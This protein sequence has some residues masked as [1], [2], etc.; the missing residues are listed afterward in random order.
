MQ[1]IDNN[2]QGLFIIFI[3]LIGLIIPVTAVNVAGHPSHHATLSGEPV[4]DTVFAEIIKLEPDP[5]VFPQ[6]P[7]VET[8]TSISMKSDYTNLTKVNE[9]DATS[10]A[11]RFISKIWYLSDEFNFSEKSIDNGWTI[12]D[13]S[14]WRFRFFEENV[15][16]YVSVNAISGKVNEF[17][18]IWSYDSPFIPDTDDS[19]FASSTQL[20]QLALDFLNQF[21]Y[22]LTTYAKYVSPTLVYSHIHHQDV[23]RISFFNLVNE[24]LIWQ[25]GIHLYIDTNA[26]A[27]LQ[28]SYSWVHIDAIPIGKIITPNEA[29]QAAV[30][31]LKDT[32]SALAFEIRSTVL[33]FEKMWTPSGQE[34]RLGW[35]VSINSDSLAAI[36]IDAKSGTPYDTS[37]HGMLDATTPYSPLDLKISRPPVSTII[38]IFIGSTLIGVVFSLIVKRQAKLSHIA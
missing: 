25:N 21:N 18:S 32:I 33:T 8:E 36:H 14:V 1:I 34:Y 26:R 38:W 16:V 29:E 35:I 24:S 9:S 37:W 13:D 11:L 12:L 19:Q 6:N 2:R 3:F 27:I 10:A 28:F 23:F 17:A 15:E 5:V 22:T 20:E 31:Y 7:I 4:L 30:D